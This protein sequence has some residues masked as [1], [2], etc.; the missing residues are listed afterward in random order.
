VERQ[1]CV[2]ASKASA[3]LRAA[4]LADARRAEHVVLTQNVVMGIHVN[5]LEALNNVHNKIHAQR[6]E[7][8]ARL[9]RQT[10]KHFVERTGRLTSKLLVMTVQVRAVVV[11]AIQKF[12]A[13]K[14]IKKAHVLAIIQ[15]MAV[16][17][18]FAMNKQ[19]FVMVSLRQE[20]ARRLMENQEIV[21]QVENVLHQL[22]PNVLTAIMIICGATTIVSIKNAN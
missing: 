6:L 3:K 14:Q 21:M 2:T 18:E 11:F 13:R 5:L 20:V 8:Y 17:R 22:N 16:L 9:L 7:E 1:T 19:E 4:K 10:A 12:N 15:L